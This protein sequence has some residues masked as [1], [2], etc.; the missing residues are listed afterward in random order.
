MIHT[1]TFKRND[2]GLRAAKG[3]EDFT[4]CAPPLPYSLL[5]SLRR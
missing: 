4:R 1:M 5:C 2:Y 3:M